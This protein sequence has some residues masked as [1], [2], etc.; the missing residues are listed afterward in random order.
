LGVGRDLAGER[1][2]SFARL[3]WLFDSFPERA[4]RFY[5]IG[6]IR[7][8]SRKQGEAEESIYF[9][10]M[11]ASPEESATGARNALHKE[12]REQLYTAIQGRVATGEVE[13]LT[14]HFRPSAK[15]VV[16]QHKELLGMPQQAL[17]AAPKKPPKFD[18]VTA[19]QKR[20]WGS[21]RTSGQELATRADTFTTPICKVADCGDT[22]MEKPRVFSREAS[23]WARCHGNLRRR[24]TAPG[25]RGQGNEFPGLGGAN[26]RPI[27]F[28]L[29][30]K[31][32][33]TCAWYSRRT[34][35]QGRL[36]PAVLFTG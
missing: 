35:L 19:P 8:L 21:S 32:S 29:S 26:V 1:P 6:F 18:P 24:Q 25:G 22:S 15:L 20:S 36:C 16:A 17:S 10:L 13:T 23:D 3:H 7:E 31:R 11:N 9:G 30:T 33:P 28:A 2:G 12:T 27:P 34:K 5:R 4:A 14:T